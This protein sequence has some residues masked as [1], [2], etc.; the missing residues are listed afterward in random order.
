LVVKQRRSRLSAHHGDGS[1][2]RRTSAPLQREIGQCPMPHLAFR[3]RR[4]CCKVQGLDVDRLS[5]AG[6][7]YVK[8]VVDREMLNNQSYHE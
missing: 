3:S 2:S 6:Y 8:L 7:F 4:Q 1:P 5:V